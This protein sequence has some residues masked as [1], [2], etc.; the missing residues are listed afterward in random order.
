MG[1][2]EHR[3]MRTWS[4][5]MTKRRLHE[6]SF[7]TPSEEIIRDKLRTEFDDKIFYLEAQLHQMHAQMAS[8]C[9][10]HSSVGDIMRRRGRYAD[11]QFQFSQTGPVRLLQ[12]SSLRLV[13][14][15]SILSPVLHH[16][17]STILLFISQMMRYMCRTDPGEYAPDAD[18]Q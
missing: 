10:A 18:P 15:H 12:H 17:H 16:Q 7:Q 14:L 8:G 2:D 13:Q 5:S 11:V 1:E 3:R 6:Q 4:S 9:F